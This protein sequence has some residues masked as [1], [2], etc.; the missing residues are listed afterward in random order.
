MGT[1]RISS[2]SRRG[3]GFVLLVV[4]L[5]GLP[6]VPAAADATITVASWGMNEARGAT[7]MTDSS[8]NRI[9]GKVGS[10]VTTG[11]TY[12]KAVGYVWPTRSANEPARPERLVLADDARLNPGS[13]DYAV[14]ARFRT[15]SSTG[16]MLQKG[17]AAS[18]GGYFKWEISKGRAKCLFRGRAKDGTV[19]SRT[20][21]SGDIPLNDGKWHTVRCERLK[22]R[23]T[24][25]I[26]GVRT[27]QML[28]PTGTIS[29]KR[30]LS[31]GGKSQ[32]DQVKV[33]CDYFTGSIDYVKIARG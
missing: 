24:M 21:H 14:T 15:T 6:A 1:E 3:L 5:L 10:A 29:N 26:D 4:G 22:D 20:V 31:I 13:G 25:T 8:A 27:R 2:R 23:V 12:D 33:G 19:L 11:Q 32:C 18:E 9:H 17:Q 30:P 16:N 7:V 28:G